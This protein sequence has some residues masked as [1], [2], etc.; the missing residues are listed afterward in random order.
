M[1]NHFICSFN[2]TQDFIICVWCSRFP[3]IAKIAHFMCS[4]HINQNAKFSEEWPLLNKRKEE[5]LT[6]A[7]ILAKEPKNDF[8]KNNCFQLYWSF[9][10]GSSNHLTIITVLR[11]IYHQIRV[12][13]LHFPGCQYFDYFLWQQISIQ[14]KCFRSPTIAFGTVFVQLKYEVTNK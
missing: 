14:Q 9:D 4:C 8:L 10:N 11:M 1:P 5:E 7:L 2:E 6:L 12:K 13:I 3:T